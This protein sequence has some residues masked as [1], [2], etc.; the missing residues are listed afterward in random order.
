M[1]TF[2]W[3]SIQSFVVMDLYCQV[4]HPVCYK[5]ELS[6]LLAF[7]IKGVPSIL[8]LCVEMAFKRDSIEPFL[9]ILWLFRMRIR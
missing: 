9:K 4:A 3:K 8:P 6:H 7:L 1:A 5:K 2:A